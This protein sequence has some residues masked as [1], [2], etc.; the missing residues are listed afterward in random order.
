MTLNYTEGIKGCGRY[1]ES[2]LQNSYFSV[3]QK[4]ATL[5]VNVDVSGK[6]DIINAFQCKFSARDFGILALKVQIFDILLDNNFT[7]PV[8]KNKDGE[9]IEMPKSIFMRFLNGLVQ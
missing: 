6:N 1:L 3:L 2:L 4:Y 7:G 5:F 8:P 9:I